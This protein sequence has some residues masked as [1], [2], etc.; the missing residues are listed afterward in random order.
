MKKLMTFAAAMTIVGG[1]YA[2]D[3]EMPTPDT[4]C[5]MVYNVKMNL[6]TVSGKKLTGA[7]VY[8]KETCELTQ[9]TDCI[10][11]PN[12][13]YRVQG[14]LVSCDCGCDILDGDFVL[15]SAPLKSALCVEVTEGSFAHVLGKQNTAEIF[16]GLEGEDSVLGELWL[17]LVGFGTYSKKAGMYGGFNGLAVGQLAQ[18]ICIG[19]CAD[20]EYWECGT[21]VLAN[22]DPSIIGGTWSMKYNPGASKA[23]WRDGS[24]LVRATP[25]YYWNA[26]CDVT[27]DTTTDLR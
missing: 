26:G 20:A 6:K 9:D 19:V 24:S 8:D 12:F 27:V 5:A 18:P 15:W 17:T 4:G 1:A 11:F 22:D 3:C 14:Y 21:L 2:A 16:F 13:P 23:Y 7:A 10:R 25:K